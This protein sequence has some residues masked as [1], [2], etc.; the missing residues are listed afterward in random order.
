MQT[1]SNTAN[2][3]KRKMGMLAP[4]LLFMKAGEHDLVAY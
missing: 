4:L 3:P 1:A 2:E